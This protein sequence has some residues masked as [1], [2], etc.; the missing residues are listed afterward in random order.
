MKKDYFFYGIL[1]LM[2]MLIAPNALAQPNFYNKIPIPPLVEVPQGDTIKLELGMYRHQFNPNSPT[3]DNVLNGYATQ[4]GIQSWAYNVLGSDTMSILG[5]TLLW[6]ANEEIKIQVTNHL[7][8]PTTTHWHGA[9]LPAK[10]DGGP[11]QPIAVDSTWMVKFVDLDQSSTMWYHPH[12]HNNTYPQVQMG[13]SGMIISVDDTDGIN[14]GLPK[15]YGVDDIPVIIGD[16][17]TD[18]TFD[19]LSGYYITEIDSGKSTRPYNIVN[20]YTNPYYEVPAHMVRLRILNGSTRKGIRFGVSDSYSGGNL[21]DFY[22]VATDGGFTMK[23]DTL[24]ELQTGPGAR[25]EIVLDLTGYSPGDVVY[26]RNMKNNL[27]YDIIGSPHPNPEYAALNPPIIVGGKDTTGGDAFLQLR[28]VADPPS[29]TPVNSAPNFV[30]TWPAGTNDTTIVDTTRHKYLTGYPDKVAQYLGVPKTGFTID[31]ITYEMMTIN[32][33][34]CEGAHE[35]WEITNNTMVAH[36]FHIHKIFFRILTIKDSLNQLVDLEPLGLNGPK[37]DILIREGWTVRF[38]AV[39]DDYGTDIA[40]DSTYMYHCHILTHEDSQ[41]GGMMHQFVVA[42]PDACATASVGE[43]KD[44]A[45]DF[46]LYPNPTNGLLYMRA[47]STENST[48][49]VI[50]MSGQVL[51]QEKLT[52]F[53]GDWPINISGISSGVYLVQ[54][55]TS[56]GS[57]SKKVIIE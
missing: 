36:P 55:E 43:L 10:Y 18:S 28:I 25:A 14:S 54:W 51:K 34:V 57:V 50:S 2:T 7:D 13:L 41:G 52:S 47:N 19:Q 37:D 35:V 42:N 4:N 24:T 20:G 1:F 45:L 6:R 39:F 31:D 33:V 46:V 23:P 53:T 44:D 15:T 30:G 17:Q 9:E 3:Q 16:A 8:Q 49:R 40:F 32:D 48:V 12:Y 38:Y 27:G 29:Y 5:P 21:N 26:L 11:H 22:L 56:K